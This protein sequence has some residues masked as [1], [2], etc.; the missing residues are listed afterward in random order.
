MDWS[1]NKLTV[2]LIVLLSA[3]PLMAGFPWHG[4]HG[5]CYDPPRHPRPANRHARAGC[6]Q[7]VAPWAH[8]SYNRAY[9]GYY[10]GGGAVHH[11]DGPRVPADGTWGWDYFGYHFDRHVVLG[12][13]HPGAPG[14]YQSGGGKYDTDGP[15]IL[16]HE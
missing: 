13:W 16:H 14:R 12:W 6:P 4:G 11:G 3:A 9:D 10:V 2:V 5:E 8:Y 1:K 15:K 7:T